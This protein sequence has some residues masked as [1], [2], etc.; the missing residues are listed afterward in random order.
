M[1]KGFSFFVPLALFFSFCLPVFSQHNEK[2]VETVLID[3]FD[4]PDQ[5]D[6]TWKIQASRFVADGYPII[7]NFKGMPNSLLPFVKEGDPEPRVLGAKVSFKRK[8]DNWFEIYPS[9]D[10]K[11]Y[12]IPFRG[13]VSQLDFWVWGSNYLY[14]MDALVRDAEGSVHI[15]PAGNLLFY[16]W[17][18]IVVKIAG[19]IRQSSSRHSIADN[20][21]F[22][23]FRFRADAAEHADDFSVFIDKFQYMA[24]G[25]THVY[26]GYNLKD[27]DFGDKKSTGDGQ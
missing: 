10:D 26:D 1:K 23:G 20:M 6:W 5:M 8:G 17:K 14:F 27:A 11:P 15:I 16:G 25:I 2:S 4:T 7:S 19:S 12:E 18:N 9:K 22:V 13:N 3:N 21:Y 24:A